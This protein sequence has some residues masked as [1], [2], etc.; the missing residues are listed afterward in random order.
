MAIT[1]V[2]AQCRKCWSFFSFFL[3]A[4]YMMDVITVS[5]CFFE[6]MRIFEL[7]EG[8]Y[9]SWLVVWTPLNNMKVNLDD[10]IP[11][12][13]KNT[14][15]VP[16]ISY[17]IFQLSIDYP[18]EDPPTSEFQGPMFCPSENTPWNRPR[19]SKWRSWKS[20]SRFPRTNMSRSIIR[21]WSTRGPAG[22]WHA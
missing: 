12:I 3:R 9:T 6:F 18:F 13:W 11:K 1:L 17:Q 8:T 22:K 20:S 14:S 19:G 7:P 21:T 16:V 4:L 10:D 2:P 5:D 15:H